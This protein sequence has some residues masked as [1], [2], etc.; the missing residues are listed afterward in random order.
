MKKFAILGDTSGD[1][2]FELAK[3]YDVYLMSYCITLNQQNYKDLIDISSKE[4]YQ[5]MYKGDV[6][7]KTAV[8]SVNEGIRFLEK[9]KNDGYEKVLMI[10]SSIKLTGMANMMEIAKANFPDMKIEII[11]G[12]SCGMGTGIQWIY[13]SMLRDEG[14][15]MEEV[16]EKIRDN[17]HNLKVM[18]LLRTFK[19]VVKS[20]RIS[21]FKGRIGQLLRI[22]PIITGEDGKVVVKEKLRGK[23]QSLYR[24]ADGIREFLVDKNNYLMSIFTADNEEEK[25]ILHDLLSKEISQA[26]LYLETELTSVLG[27]HVGPKT[28]GVAVYL[29]PE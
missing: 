1:F 26:K 7:F 19:Y 5:E 6:D 2:D 24:L 18:A 15:T 11:D 12:T 4:I 28:I 29:L 10:T 16:A 27:G 23:K 17:L 25:M 14:L 13:A 21:H 3:K 9:I 8:P 20:G 22:Y